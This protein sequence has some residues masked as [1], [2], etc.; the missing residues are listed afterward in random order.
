[1]RI[2]FIAKVLDRSELGVEQ[3]RFDFIADTFGGDRK[4]ADGHATIA[5]SMISDSHD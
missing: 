5:P 1:M 2:P 3:D 4:R